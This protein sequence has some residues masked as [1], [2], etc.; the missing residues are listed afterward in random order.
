MDTEITTETTIKVDCPE[1]SNCEPSDEN[2]EICKCKNDENK[3]G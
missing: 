1:G 2:K 3:E